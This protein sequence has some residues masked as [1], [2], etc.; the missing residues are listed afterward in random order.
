MEETVRQIHKEESLM[1]VE[2]KIAPVSKIF[3]LQGEHE[4]R[5]SEKKYLP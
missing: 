3:A 2:E 5:E 4:L 1:G